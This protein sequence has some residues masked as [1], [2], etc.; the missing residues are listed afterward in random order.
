MEVPL[1]DLKAQ[2]RQVGARVSRAIAGVMKHRRFILGPEVAELE[3]AMEKKTG[4]AH[5]IGCASGSDAL[6]LSLMALELNPGDE[7]I[8]TPYTFF[9]SV[10]CITRLGLR[11]VFTDICPDTF[12]MRVDQIES[13]ITPRTR[14]ILP[15]HLFGLCTDMVPLM[16]LARK[17][18]LAVIED[19]AQAILAGDHGRQAGTMG[20]AGCLSFFP[21]KNLGCD[22]DGGMVLTNDDAFAE[23]IRILRVHGSHPE[24][25]HRWVGINS[26]LD[27]LQA[28]ILLAK[29]PFLDRWTRARLRNAA[30]YRKLFGQAGLG[31]CV[32]L[33]HEPEG[34]AHVY[35]QFVIRVANREEL[36][37][38]LAD[39]RIG[40][41]V[42]YPIPL[43]LQECFGYLGCRKGDFPAAEKLAETSLAL[44]V[45]PELTLQQQRYVVDSIAE[46]CR[47]RG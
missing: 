34:R 25:I 24:Y 18:N 15:V 20:L 3:R 6:L 8:T 32:T 16:E 26:R 7:V 5:A 22:G 1:L 17:K 33:P 14:A 13:R 42:Y 30:N 45:Y 35:N 29:L 40:C 36:R 11:P 39:R 9:A 37:R 38:H 41:K 21:A 4:A 2:Q 44:P 10:S 19:A 46:F 31:G 23:K 12:Q 43:H 47:R 27:T 28:A